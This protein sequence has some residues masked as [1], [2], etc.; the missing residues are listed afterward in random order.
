MCLGKPADQTLIDAKWESLDLISCDDPDFPNDFFLFIAV[1]PLVSA[2]L[3][4]KF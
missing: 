1:G 3:D 2:L 4:R